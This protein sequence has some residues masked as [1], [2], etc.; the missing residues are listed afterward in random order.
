MQLQLHNPELMMQ[1]AY[2]Q[3]LQSFQASQDKQIP[4]QPKQML[5]PVKQKPVIK[6]PIS[7][8]RMQQINLFIRKLNQLIGLTLKA[9]DSINPIAMAQI[10]KIGMEMGIKWQNYMDP[11]FIKS[12]DFV[13]FLK[14]K[15]YVLFN[16][17]LMSKNMSLF[18]QIQFMLQASQAKDQ[19]LALS[20]PK[21][22]T[23][24]ELVADGP[25][26]P[27]PVQAKEEAK[28]DSSA[29]IA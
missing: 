9:T 28:K 10:K 1:Q 18:A 17:N 29:V 14:S 7:L 24:Q 16:N 19:K 22:S 8:T 11:K 27:D 26:S 23:K 2:Q 12:K 25:A 5:S 21:D 20:P 13:T 4:M 15:I 3:Q 6:Q